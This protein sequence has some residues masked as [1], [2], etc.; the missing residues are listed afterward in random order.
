MQPPIAIRI[1]RA[2]SGRDKIAVCGL[3]KVAV[4]DTTEL[5]I[6]KYYN[7]FKKDYEDSKYYAESIYSAWFSL[8]TT[9][10]VSEK[11]VADTVE[12]DMFKN[13]CPINDYIL[14]KDTDCLEAHAETSLF[15][16]DYQTKT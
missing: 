15:Y 13:G 16:L 12:A 11:L 4:N 2:Y 3:E 10:L 1:A 6:T 5:K 14:C 9:T 8:N 7:E